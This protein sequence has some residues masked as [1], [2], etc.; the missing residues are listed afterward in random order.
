MSRGIREG[1]A[2]GHCVSADYSFLRPKF[3]RMR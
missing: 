3:L 2:A 1:E